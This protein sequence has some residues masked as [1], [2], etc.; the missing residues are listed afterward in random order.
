MKKVFLTLCLF[1]GI[2]SAAHADECESWTHKGYPVTME[3]CSYS[4]GGSG[5]YKITNDGSR[6]A[7]ICWSVVSNDGQK[8]RGCN[9]NLDAGETSQG[10]CFQCGKKNGGAR[11]ILLESYKAR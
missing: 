4:N 9:S 5:Y 10:S 3:A 6:S 1:M 8:S 2:A 11:H 7:E